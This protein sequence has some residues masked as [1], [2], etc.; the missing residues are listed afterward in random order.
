MKIK[1][2]NVRTW[3]PKGLLNGSPNHLKIDE[4]THLVTASAAKADFGAPEASGGTP[5]EENVSKNR[6]KKRVHKYKNMHINFREN[7]N[8]TS[9]FLCKVPWSAAVWAKPTWIITICKRCS[10]KM[11]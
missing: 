6:K 9:T 4:K 11:A 8:L 1:V 7:K 10:V 5:P 3:E 2:E